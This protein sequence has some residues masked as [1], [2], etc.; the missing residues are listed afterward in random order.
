MFEFKY[1]TPEKKG[2]S[3]ANIEK[4]LKILERRK[5]STHD[6]IIMRGDEIALEKYWKPFDE[7][8]HH[9][10]YSVTKSILSI[11]V[12][13]AVQEGYFTLNTPMKEL[14]PE[15]FS[16]QTDENM[17]A[18]T[19]RDMLMMSTAKTPRDWFGARHPDRV[20]F[21]FE[22][23]DYMSR[24]GGTIYE[25]DSPG[26]LFSEQLLKGQLV[27]HLWTISARA[28]LTK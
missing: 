4:Y 11:A 3:S 6:M 17:S 10:M 5:L 23:D 28:S 1:T 13:F 14:L 24:P 20:R 8:F 9:R 15:E 19:V 22:N 27:W 7:N 12:G 26:S 16:L 25:Y 18:L 2:I 21:Y